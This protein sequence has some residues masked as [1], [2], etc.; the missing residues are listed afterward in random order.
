[1]DFVSPFGFSIWASFRQ[2]SPLQG[3]WQIDFKN[4]AELILSRFAHW[5]MRC[6]AGDAII[7]E[8]LASLTTCFCLQVQAIRRS[9]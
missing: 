9:A 6:R 3:I 1:I 8:V 2:H 5:S 7:S 4:N